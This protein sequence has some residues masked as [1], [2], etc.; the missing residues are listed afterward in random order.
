MPQANEG[1]EGAE[2]PNGAPEKPQLPEKPISKFS[3]S[4]GKSR[5]KKKMVIIAVVVAVIFLAFVIIGKPCVSCFKFNDWDAH[6]CSYCNF[7]FW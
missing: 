6:Y 2:K 3:H 7:P 1:L 4:F 5:K